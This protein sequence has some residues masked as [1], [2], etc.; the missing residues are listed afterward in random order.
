MK[1]KVI[2]GSIFVGGMLLLV[3][4][5]Y[6]SQTHP[7]INT[8]NNM[9]NT[10]P[11]VAKDGSGNIIRLSTGAAT[12]SGTASKTSSTEDQQ[13]LKDMMNA[14]NLTACQKETT[15][16]GKSQCE[17]RM[18][19]MRATLQKNPTACNTIKNPETL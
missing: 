2:Y 16:A 13:A 17:D 6:F 1:N 9:T 15:Q 3:V 10:Q 5:Y 19:L 8:G 4:S 12:S 14:P 11:R 7:S 18:M